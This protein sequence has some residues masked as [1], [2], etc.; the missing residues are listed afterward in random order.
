M[1]GNTW[2]TAILG[3]KTYVDLQS[4]QDNGPSTL[5]FGI[6]AIVGDTLEVQVVSWVLGLLCRSA[7]AR[8]TF[9]P[10]GSM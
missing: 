10:K 7:H 1:L 3:Y 4:G 9:G 2:A 6:Q 8:E 5:C